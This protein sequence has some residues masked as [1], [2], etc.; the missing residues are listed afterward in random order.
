M[1]PFFFGLKDWWSR[2]T[3]DVAGVVSGNYSTE[4]IR[5][6]LDRG[7]INAHTWLRHAWTQRY[8]LVGEALYANQM[9][10]AAEF[11]EWFPLRRDRTPIATV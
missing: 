1:K 8:A 7:E 11:E 9:A 4:D 10:T 2:W 3:I 5:A 6:K